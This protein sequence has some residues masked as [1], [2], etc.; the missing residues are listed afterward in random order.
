MIFA[1]QP[2][3]ADT[4][5]AAPGARLCDVNATRRLPIPALSRLPAGAC[6]LAGAWL[7]AS[8]DTLRW[9]AAT[10]TAP[11]QRTNLVL[12]AIAAALVLGSVR[13]RAPSIA[14][15]LRADPRPRLWALA[16]LA[17]CAAVQWARPLLWDIRIAAASCFVL[18]SYALCGLFMA[19]RTWRRGL[20]AALAVVLV[21]PFGVHLDTYL[22]FPARV[23]SAKVAHALLA[24][25]VPV[26]SAEALLVFEGGIADVD[27]PCS[28]VKS[29]WTGAM[30]LLG[31][32][33][34][35]RRVVGWR[36]LAVA[37]LF[38]AMLVVGNIGRV[39]ALAALHFA[40]DASGAARLLHQPIGGL[41]FIAAGALLV[42]GLRRFVPA[43]PE[44]ASETASAS[45]PS[46]DRPTAALTVALTAALLL[47]AVSARYLP[48]RPTADTR[49]FEPAEHAAADLDVR[50]QKLRLSAQEAGLFE[51]HEAGFAGKWRFDI[52]ASS[53]AAAPLSG[54]LMVVRSRSFR[55]HHAP[56][57]CLAAAGHRID[58]VQPRDL[59][60]GARAEPAADPPLHGRWLTLDR[61]RSAAAYWYQHAAGTEPDLLARTLGELLGGRREWLQVS[62]LLDAPASPAEP[63]VRAL[64]TSV[65]AGLDRA[66]FS[67]PTNAPEPS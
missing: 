16:V 2:R 57:V 38:A 9:L 50:W 13:R 56:E 67:P 37:L 53:P 45:A 24:G 3:R 32:T 66:F 6:L 4:A 28:G 20:P 14:A 60:G 62:V 5:V 15:A 8:A 34:L 31:A 54:S 43:L 36:W 12:A 25:V 41:V 35:E 10:M 58:A 59:A 26:Q 44:A 11:E 48:A 18:G 27:L 19:P 65:R 39:V 7:L 22:G 40:A 30:L 29:L 17:V 64:L 55:S 1:R 49:R 47:A 61:G 51:R 42:V 52:A 46:T 33:W 21:L 23:L 63:R